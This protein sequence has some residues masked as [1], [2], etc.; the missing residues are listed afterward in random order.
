M[1]ATA[2]ARA[3]AIEIGLTGE[4]VICDRS[5]ALWLPAD[6]TLVVSDLHLEKGSSF[7]RRGMLL[8]P[9]DTLVTLRLLDEAVPRY[10]PAIVVSLGDAFHDEEAAAR[11]PP[12]WRDMLLGIMA[13][14]DWIWVAGNHDPSRPA[15]LPGESLSEV[16]VGVLS[17]RHEPSRTKAAGEVAGHLHPG[18]RIVRR[19]RSVRRAC[20]I[21]DGDRLILPAFGAYTGA[22]NVLDRAFHGLFRKERLLALMLGDACLYPIAGAALFPG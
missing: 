19:G 22:L 11:M 7:A 15:G 18:G 10:D 3:Q 4:T 9:Y 12:L 1:R 16:A 5:G 6:R 20:F 17:F 13:G 14:R 2:K 8:P 21:T